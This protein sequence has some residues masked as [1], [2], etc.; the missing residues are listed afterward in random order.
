MLYAVVRGGGGAAGGGAGGG[1]AGV[2]DGGG[3]TIKWMESVPL[4][5]EGGG[6]AE[7]EAEE[8]RGWSRCTFR[9]P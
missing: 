8:V 6:G 2:V 7:C 5:V 1:G 3:A 9:G 4:P